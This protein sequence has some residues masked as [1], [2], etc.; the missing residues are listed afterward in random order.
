MYRIAIVILMILTC[1]L[2]LTAAAAEG[3]VPK[4]A[5]M[6][7]Q[8]MDS[9]I[10][11]RVGTYPEGRMCEHRFNC[12]SFFGESGTVESLGSS[13]GGRGHALF[14]RSRLPG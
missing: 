4:A 12:P 6:M 13:D 8:Q 2:P 10:M 7:A 14:C 3:T 1:L 5:T 9:Q 11:R